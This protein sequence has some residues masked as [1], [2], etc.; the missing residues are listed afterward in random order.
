MKVLSR[1]LMK[2]CFASIKLNSRGF[3]QSDFGYTKGIKQ[4]KRP[5]GA[6]FEIMEKDLR[7]LREA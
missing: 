2:N 3:T 1:K 6:L 4:K 7:G 5:Q